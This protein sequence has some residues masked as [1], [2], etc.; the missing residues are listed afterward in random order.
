MTVLKK[1]KSGARLVWVY[2]STRFIL[3][4]LDSVIN[5]FPMNSDIFGRIDSY[6]HLVTLD[7]QDGDSDI[8][9]NH[10]CFAYSAS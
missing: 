4:F 5:L 10:Q 7:A 3:F 9:T 1:W 8:V 6:S 2:I